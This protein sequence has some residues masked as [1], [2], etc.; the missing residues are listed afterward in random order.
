M[1]PKRRFLHHYPLLIALLLAIALRAVILAAGAVPFN[2]DEAVVAL[3]ARHTLQGEWPAFVYGQ[4]YMGSLDATLLAAAFFLL[5]QSVIVI[6]VVQTALFLGTI[7]T[8]YALGLRIYGVRWVAAAAA[9]LLALPTVL[10]STYTTATLGGYGETLLLGN[11]A[12][13]LGHAVLTDRRSDWQLPASGSRRNRLDRTAF[14][15]VSPAK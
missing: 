1:E 5:G 9:V 12:L 2:S 11:L 8:T 4:S 13:L 3:M 15:M 7:A 14:P 6:L 10:V